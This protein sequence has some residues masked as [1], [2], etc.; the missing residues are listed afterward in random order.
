MKSMNHNV[1]NIKGWVKSFSL[2]CLFV[3]LPFSAH[4]V[5]KESADSAYAQQHYQEAIKQYETL[6]QQ[7]VSA[8][9]YYN[10]GNAYYRSDNYTRAILNYERA[11]LLEPGDGDIRH[12]LQL[13]RQKTVDKLS[14]SAD[15]FLVTWYRSV[16]NLMGVD[17]W[18]WTAL[19]VLF[20]AIVLFLVYLF[21]G[22]V[23]LQKLG[24]F[25]AVLM[26]LL[27]LMSNVFAWHQKHMLTNR[28]GAIVVASETSVKS[29]PAQNG[30]DLFRLH[31]GTRVEIT[32]ASMKDWKE[33]RLPD[34][35]EGWIATEAI[36]VI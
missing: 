2:F 13:A 4:A 7:G 18:G 17:A 24:F 16:V 33:V 3:L 21:S 34:G 5:S 19:V 22:R 9:I 32:D 30:T 26:V 28:T 23:A 36:E 25:G 10:L 35:K 20:L 29:T 8:D 14:P 31:E 1:N 27:F 15:F 11:L 6:L 12:N